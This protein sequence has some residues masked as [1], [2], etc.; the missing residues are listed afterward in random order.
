MR[1]ANSSSEYEEA[2][3]DA[4]VKHRHARGGVDGQPTLLSTRDE[5]DEEGD[6][7]ELSTDSLLS[8]LATGRPGVD[9]LL[10]SMF[11][12]RSADGETEHGEESVLG[13]HEPGGDDDDE[14]EKLGLCE[15]QLFADGE[16]DEE[17][18][19]DQSAVSTPVHHDDEEDQPE[20]SGDKLLADSVDQTPSTDDQL[21]SS[22]VT[23]AEPQEDHPIS[24]VPAQATQQSQSQPGSK[25]SLNPP[26]TCII[27]FDVG[28]KLFR[29]K[30]SLIRKF[31]R[32]RLNQV[33]SCGCE[34]IGHDTFFIDRN[35]QHFEVIL[36]WYRTGT[37][38]RHLHVSEQA[39]IEDAKYFDLFEELFPNKVIIQQP[40]SEAEHTMASTRPPPRI[41]PRPH[42][43]DSS[44][45]HAQHVKPVNRSEPRDNNNNQSSMDAMRFCKT[46]H[47]VV[48][49][50][51]APV[52]FMIRK[53]EHLLVAS[54]KGRGKLLVRVCDTTGLKEIQV[55]SAVLFDSQSCFY[56]QG[57]RAKLQHCLLPGCHTYTFWMELDPGEINST[58][59]ELDVEFKVL[60]T[61]LRDEQ[62]TDALDEELQSLVSD[63]AVAD[64][65]PVVQP[66]SASGNARTVSTYSPYMFLP[67]R[68][69][70]QQQPAP[71]EYQQPEQVQQT[72]PGSN[73]RR[74]QFTSVLLQSG[75]D[76]DAVATQLLSQC[77][78]SPKHKSS[79]QTK[80]LTALE[81]VGK[82]AQ[83]GPAQSFDSAQMKALTSPIKRNGAAI[84]AGSSKAAATRKNLD[85][86]QQNDAGKIT[87]Y[88]HA[89]LRIEQTP[90]EPTHVPSPRDGRAKKKKQ[91]E[92]GVTTKYQDHQPRLFR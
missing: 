17:R 12:E 45:S 11:T 33:I 28:G 79:P 16:Q 81:K 38:V 54:V 63:G 31:P 42:R 57:G 62:L 24:C 2:D 37:Y 88:Q 91:Q 41:P 21:R 9:E 69:A 84:V 56:L 6:P 44:Q 14:Q 1:A 13:E 78:T 23:Y 25:P 3:G 27:A 46:E 20:Q 7:N 76:R 43:L 50:D 68:Y 52:V 80:V 8:E 19:P 82:T 18:N 51:N 61:F 83:S 35:P 5:S 75:G 71:S 73:Q 10:E 86:N 34:K 67:P 77:N 66:T 87:I 58:K 4:G 72:D 55:E 65:F 70:Q 32:K 39:L 36:D 85:F 26:A 40:A 47:R 60:S 53:H 64:P 15:E 74:D 89:P 59:H 48:Q 30:E 92:E 90:R 49:A 29:C 22:V